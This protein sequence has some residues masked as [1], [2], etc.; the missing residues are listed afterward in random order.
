MKLA[1]IKQYWKYFGIVVL[2]IFS[3]LFGIFVWRWYTTSSCRTG[4]TV[5][6]HGTVGS[7]LHALNPFHCYSDSASDETLS[8][9]LNR[10]Y[11][12]HPLIQQDQ[13]LMDEGLHQVSYDDIVAFR[14]GNS[15]VIDAR[16]A[17]YP[18]IAGYDAVSHQAG[19]AC[20]DER[21]L[22]YGWNGLLSNKARRKAGY[23]LYDQL[24]DYVDQVRNETG[25]DPVVRIVAHSHGGNVALWL[26]EAEQEYERNVSVDVLCMLGTPIQNETGDCIASPFFKN[27]TSLYSHGDGVQSSDYFSTSVHQSY[28]RMSDIRDLKDIIETHSDCIRRDVQIVMNDDCCRITHVNMWFMGRSEKVFDFVDPLPFVVLVPTF[29]VNS[30]RHADCVSSQARFYG[31]H[32]YCSVHIVRN[33][34]IENAMMSLST[35]LY[36]PLMLAREQA[37]ALWSPDDR[38][39]NLIFNYKNYSA[40]KHAF[41]F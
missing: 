24:A 19:V 14:E 6:V 41:G 28:Q 31:S 11:R 13:L 26:A 16:M 4:I 18:I 29:F 23:A 27:I 17:V 8:W 7:E 12:N 10:R 35:N 1:Y 40:L 33:D 2:A 3:I 9:R 34:H 5:F 39:R 38:S 21:Y 36:M 15:D 25:A 22:L 37:L 30:H 32:G 20:P